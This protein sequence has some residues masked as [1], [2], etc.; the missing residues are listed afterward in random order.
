MTK[1]SYFYEVHNIIGIKS[2]T[3][4]LPIGSYFL[5]SHIDSPALIIEMAGNPLQ[6]IG[7]GKWFYIG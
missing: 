3:Q 1:H 6:D 4:N 2:D 5:K 7:D